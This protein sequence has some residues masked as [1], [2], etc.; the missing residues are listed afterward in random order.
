MSMLTSYIGRRTLAHLVGDMFPALDVSRGGVITTMAT[1]T[2]YVIRESTQGGQVLIHPTTRM[3][4][5]TYRT[6]RN[7]GWHVDGSA[8]AIGALLLDLTENGW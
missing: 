1:G 7:L 4:D 8:R 5:G 3:D 6:V 2:S